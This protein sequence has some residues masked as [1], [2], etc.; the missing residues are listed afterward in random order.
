VFL[1]PS[2][3][4]ELDSQ[5]GAYFRSAKPYEPSPDEKAA[6]LTLRSLAISG[7]IRSSNCRS[8]KHCRVRHE[9]LTYS[10]VAGVPNSSTQREWDRNRR[11]ERTTSRMIWF[12]KPPAGKKRNL[13]PPIPWCAFGFRENSYHNFGDLAD[14][15][16]C[17]KNSV[18]ILSAF[19]SVP[20]RR[21]LPIKIYGIGLRRK[22]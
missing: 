13:C 20:Q 22:T 4:N 5:S 15:M 3:R 18:I 1:T 16:C 19:P 8:V 6:M 7:N 9:L 10:I 21:V 2:T 17:L 12:S 11:S 14:E